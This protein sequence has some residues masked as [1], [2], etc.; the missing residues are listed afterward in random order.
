MSTLQQQIEESGVGVWHYA[1]QCF[2]P[3]IPCPGEERVRI[4][5]FDG[6]ENYGVYRGVWSGSTFTLSSREPL[7]WRIDL[8]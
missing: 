4:D 2:V 8:S 5:V 3:H 7:N 1:R 6:L